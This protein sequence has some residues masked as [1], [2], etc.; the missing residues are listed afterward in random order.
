MPGQKIITRSIDT[1][2]YCLTFISSLL[3]C[4]FFEGGIVFSY[5]C[6]TK[7]WP[8]IRAHKYFSVKALQDSPN[9]ANHE[10]VSKI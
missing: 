4:K 8:V 9:K 6:K 1:C 10:I 2:N 5:I 3:D 7:T